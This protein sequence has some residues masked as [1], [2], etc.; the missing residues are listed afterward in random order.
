MCS[1]YCIW[2]SF[3]FGFV[4][5]GIVCVCA[6]LCLV[7]A[8]VFVLVCMCALWPRNAFLWGWHASGRPTYQPTRQ[9]SSQA[10][11]WPIKNSPL[12]HHIK[13]GSRIQQQLRRTFPAIF[14]ALQGHK[15][16]SPTACI[17]DWRVHM[18]LKSVIARTLKYPH[19]PAWS[20]SMTNFHQRLPSSP[21]RLIIKSTRAV[22]LGRM[23]QEN[24]GESR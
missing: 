10:R 8:Y 5:F 23:C 17:A 7:Y 13:H 18:K 16:L 9:P 19:Q 21:T 1:C 3:S 20:M 2:L 4:C 6:W 24:P 11:P 15:K 22:P 12:L 14:S